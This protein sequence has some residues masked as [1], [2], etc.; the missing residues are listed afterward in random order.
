MRAGELRTITAR[1]KSYLWTEMSRS[2]WRLN[3]PVELPTE[4]P[5]LFQEIVN[6][7]SVELGYSAKDLSAVVLEPIE[8][9]RRVFL[10]KPT[11]PQI[12]A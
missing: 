8:Q 4:Q 11:G 10:P 5:T 9:V 12:V 3:E 6:V 2:G 1:R 7:Y